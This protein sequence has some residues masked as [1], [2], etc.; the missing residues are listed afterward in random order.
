MRI[1]RDDIAAI[2]VSALLLCIMAGLIVLRATCGQQG[3]SKPGDYKAFLFGEGGQSET[4]RVGEEI[5]TY[6]PFDINDVNT[7][8]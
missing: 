4:G 5:S 6:F 1:T 3:Q 8:F 7:L 2:V